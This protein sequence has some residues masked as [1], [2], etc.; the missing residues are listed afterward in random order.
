MVHIVDLSKGELEMRGRKPFEIEDAI[1]KA[2]RKGNRSRNDIR[3]SAGITDYR[4]LK[5]YTD[6]LIESGKIKEE[7][8]NFKLDH[9]HVTKVYV[10][11]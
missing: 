11:R 1:I 4:M 2:I 3:L 9:R 6:K 10:I 7:K 8:P 5:K